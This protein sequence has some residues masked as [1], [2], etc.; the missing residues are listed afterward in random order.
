MKYWIRVETPAQ[1]NRCADV[2]L[3]HGV[4]K[5]DFAWIK[6]KYYCKRGV[7]FRSSDKPFDQW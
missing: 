5:S 2:L 1:I 4:G 7:S 6:A 3:F